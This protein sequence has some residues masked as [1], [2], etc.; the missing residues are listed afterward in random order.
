MESHVEESRLYND[1][2]TCS[3]LNL[4]DFSE[5]PSE[6]YVGRLVHFVGE[7]NVDDAALDFGGPA[8]GG[9][10]VSTPVPRAVVMKRTCYIYQKFEDSANSTKRNMVGGGETRTTSYTLREDWTPMGPQPETLQN[11]PGEMNSRGIWDG[12]I[13]AAGPG[14]GNVDATI[15]ALPEG[16]AEKMGLFDSN[17]APHSEV[18][19]PVAHVGGFGLSRDIVANNPTVF[20]RALS[21]VP[22]A[23]LP[24]KVDG[25]AGLTK[26]SDNVLRTFPEGQEPQ[27]GDCKVVYEYA[28][29]GF[30][31]SFVVQQISA[32]SDI[33]ANAEFGVDKFDIVDE[34]CFGKWN[35]ELGEIWMVRKGRFELDEMVKMAKQDEQKVVKLIRIVAW[36]LLCAGWVMLFSPFTTALQVLPILSQLGYFAVVLTALIVSCL[37]CVTVTLLAYIRYR[38]LLAFSLLALAGG[39]WGIVIWRLNEAVEEGGDEEA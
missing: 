12:L 15:A 30:E 16:L 7:V 28:D 10:N 33:E 3:S 6:D 34:H 13:A 32:K 11:L 38:P 17:Q 24:E 26:G 25:C 31:C 22:A 9:L 2:L 39:I 27:N 20:S 37:C 5:A 35:N 23:F 8:L 29:D 19:S 36:V 4:Y 14:S 18:V 1:F 21:G